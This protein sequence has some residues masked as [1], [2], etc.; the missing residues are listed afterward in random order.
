MCRIKFIFRKKSEKFFKRHLDIKKKFKRGIIS[1][2]IGNTNI[3]I[4]KLK[5]YDKLYRMRIGSYRVIFQLSYDIEIIIVDVIDA[6]L[7]KNIYKK[8]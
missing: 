4:K 1:K 5:G 6:N 7:R 2:L 8:I 3:D